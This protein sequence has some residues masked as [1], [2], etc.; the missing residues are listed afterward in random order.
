M[1]DSKSKNPYKKAKPDMAQA[2]K[3]AI[4][5]AVTEL[6]PLC[7]MD[8]YNNW[9]KIISKV[10]K[11][12]DEPDFLACEK[13]L[14]TS[15]NIGLACDSAQKTLYAM[16]R[17]YGKAGAI[18]SAVKAI[19]TDT[20]KSSNTL[21][22]AQSNITQNLEAT[23]GTSLNSVDKRVIDSLVKTVTNVR[24]GC[25]N[26]K[27]GLALFSQLTGKEIAETQLG[28]NL[29]FHEDDK[30]I[31]SING[32]VDGIT[33]DGYV[34]EI[35]NRQK[36]LFNT[37][38]DYEM[39]Q[40]QLYLHSLNIERGYLVELLP[41]DTEKP[42]QYNIIEVPRDPVYYSVTVEPWLQ[43]LVKYCQETLLTS[44]DTR[45]AILRGDNDRKCFRAYCLAGKPN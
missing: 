34:V 17:K 42:T 25:I 35:K 14:R 43:H 40:I 45:L 20:T 30:F 6:A 33:T 12:L 8:N 10:W 13:Q 23:L 3:M 7:T 37:V 18:T 2:K 41:G 16:E 38:R 26:E 39:C 5:I 22:T 19:N 44:Q 28:V 4:S 15:G 32:K 36:V 1:S 27:G 11:K 29:K 9:A 24:H 31:W 21:V